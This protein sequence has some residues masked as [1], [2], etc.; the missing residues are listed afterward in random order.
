MMHIRLTILSILFGISVF[1]Q[2]DFEDNF[3]KGKEKFDKQEFNEAIGFFNDA[4]K[5]KSKA[6]NNYRIAAALQAKAYSY[7]Y[8]KKYS[9]ALKE[10][11]EAIELKP[12]YSDL[13]YTITMIHLRNKQYDDCIEWAD[14][15]LTIK[16]EFEE[17]LLLRAAAKGEK[18]EFKEACLDYDSVLMINPRNM[19][20]LYSMS[21]TKAHMKLYDEAIK[22]SDKAIEID[23]QDP[24]A[25]Y[26][27][28]ISKAYLKDF[29]GSMVDMQ[30]GISVDTSM[31]WLGYNNIGFFINLEKKDYQGA[32]TYFDDAVKIN[33]EFAYAYSN[34]GFTKMKL[35][36]LR[37]ARKDIEKSISMDS[38]NSYAY[39]NLALLLIAEKKESQACEQ[40][41]KSLDLGYA[42][43]YDDEVDILVKQYC[44]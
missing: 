41:K 38:K 43:E 30:R 28:A 44:K 14:K 34:R 8:L 1:A 26:N 12:E 23:A 40:L 42:I 5:N 21:G 13:Y 19:Q 3:N 36:D 33:P 24:A 6:K 16:P 35:G 32:L 7:M 39:K 9:P 4:L 18:K 27:R 15:G 25:F 11:K 17:L 29:E 37:G 10:I 31:R 22:Y 20:A 2:N